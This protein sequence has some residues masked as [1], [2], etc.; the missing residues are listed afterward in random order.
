MLK[1]SEKRYYFQ[2]KLKYFEYF[3][4]NMECCCQQRYCEHPTTTKYFL[5]W[6]FFV[7]I[8]VCS[9]D[10]APQLSISL[11]S[12][13]SIQIFI[14]EWT[15][16][17]TWVSDHPRTRIINKI[18][19]AEKKSPQHSHCQLELFSIDWLLTLSVCIV[20]KNLQTP[21]LKQ[22]SQMKHQ[23]RSE[24][25]IMDTWLEKLLPSNDLKIWGF[26]DL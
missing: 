19:W 16:D 18:P 23:Q 20:I 10:E 13:W 21:H 11:V 5:F 9:I 4:M 3:T 7:M 25:L 8:L 2:E 22:H 14:L 1:A 6:M 17:K 15:P 26:I 12:D 24:T